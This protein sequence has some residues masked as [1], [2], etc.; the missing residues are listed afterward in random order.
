MADAMCP[1]GK[2][3]LSAASDLHAA[4]TAQAEGDVVLNLSGVA[5]MGALCLQVC[6]AAAQTLKAQGYK[7]QVVD[8][9][10]GVLAQMQ[11]MGFTPETL[12]EGV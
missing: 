7:L 5:Q 8:T 1:K 11:S 10:D 9:P 3:D 4:F 6:I 2:L 12:S